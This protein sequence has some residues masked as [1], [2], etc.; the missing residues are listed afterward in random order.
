MRGYGKI[1]VRITGHVY[2]T[3]GQFSVD[4]TH[5]TRS[6]AGNHNGTGSVT[7]APEPPRMKMNFERGGW[8]WDDQMLDRPVDVT[9]VEDANGRQHIVTGGRFVG[10][11][12]IDLTT[13]EVSG[14]EIMWDPGDYQAVG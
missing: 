1:S 14:C 2:N 7:Y 10:R 13:G 12:S 6:A 9:A 4:P 5:F 3:R 11:P 8:V